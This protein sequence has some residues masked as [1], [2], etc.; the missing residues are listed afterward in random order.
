VQGDCADD[1]KTVKP[2]NERECVAKGADPV[3]MSDAEWRAVSDLPLRSWT[4]RSRMSATPTRVER[5][6]HP[7][8]DVHNHLGLW[9]SHDGDWVAKDVP[10]LIAAMDEVN[11]QAIVNLDGRWDEELTANL[12]RYDRAHPGRFVTFCQID[13]DRLADPDGERVLL[14]QL[15]ASAAAGA[16]GVK[17]W[18]NLGLW[19]RDADG[20][21]IQPDDPRVIAILGRAGELGLPVLIH[22]A[23][24][25]AF[26]DPLDEHNERLD[27]LMQQRDWW[28]GDRDVYPTFDRIVEGLA[29]LVTATP[30]TTYIGAHVGCDA[31]DLDWVEALMDRAPNFTVDTGGR[32]AELG[33]QPRRFRRLIER[34]PD[35]VLFGTDVYPISADAYRHAFRFFETA[36]ESFEYAPGS[37][38]PPQ[39]RW[40][41]SALELDDA[42]LRAVYHD[43]AARV[44][45][46]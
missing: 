6:A 40:A 11:V 41:V 26:F 9:L 25:K 3:T 4:P 42:A 35:R 24:P 16:R 13:W 29:T 23:D 32:M 22:V 7:V 14:R 45:G 38:I 15:E 17:V 19:V 37:P 30:G 39:G 27:E 1:K 8:V 12:D 28:F 20:S 10:G 18:K 43:N 31:E 44:L 5:A 33:R 36:D 2:L 34:H 21:L 46:L